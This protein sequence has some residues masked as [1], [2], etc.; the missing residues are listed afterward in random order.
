MLLEKGTVCA[1]ALG[2]ERP[3]WEEPAPPHLCCLRSSPP[4]PSLLG[5][6]IASLIWAGIVPGQAAHPVPGHCLCLLLSAPESL[7]TQRINSCGGTWQVRFYPSQCQAGAA[8]SDAASSLA[9]AGRW[10]KRH[11]APAWPPSCG[12]PAGLTSWGHPPAPPTPLTPC[13]QTC[14]V[15]SVVSYSLRPRGL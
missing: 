11:L 13:M 9:G 3:T 10:P 15:A 7:I 4:W 6:T 12:D 5:T 2:R 1:E 14:Q 8:R